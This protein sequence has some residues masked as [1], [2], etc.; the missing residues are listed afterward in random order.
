VP[1]NLG[2]DPLLWAELFAVSNL[3]FLAV[4]IFVAHS[5]NRF[6]NPVEWLPVALS[7]A[8]APTLLLTMVLGGP[9]PRLA[10]TEEPDRADRQRLARWVG[11]AVG[12]ASVGVGV[13]GLIFHL[14]SQFFEEQ[15]LKNLVYTAPFAAPLAYAGLG[16]LLIL[17]RRVDARTV[18]WAR[19]IAFLAW[20]GFVGN[21]VL[22]LADHAQNAFFHPLEW[23]S[24]AAASFAVGGLLALVLFPLDRIT[25][26][27]VVVLMALQVLVG[28]VGTAAHTRAI[29][30]GPMGTPWENALYGA[31]A[32]AP[33]LFADLAVLAAL[34]LWALARHTSATTRPVPGR[35][36]S[37]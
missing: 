26:R 5:V 19:W 1:V 31:P 6:A 20:G 8:A 10:G 2:R 18:D 12:W 14:E 7:L 25:H 3:A 32:F 29:L 4:D 34:A 17:D 13:A 22:S 28:V 30:G 24:V 36:D 9:L 21:F 35:L 23:A 11:L 37:P 15:T 16:L 27:V 33:M